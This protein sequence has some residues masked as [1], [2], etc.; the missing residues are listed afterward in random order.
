MASATSSVQLKSTEQWPTTN[1]IKMPQ[2]STA[3]YTCIYMGN[4]RTNSHKNN[5]L[6]YLVLKQDL[7]KSHVYCIVLCNYI[8]IIMYYYHYLCV[9]IL[10]LLNTERKSR[11]YSIQSYLSSYTNAINTAGYCIYETS[12][13]FQQL[14]I[15]HCYITCYTVSICIEFK[16]NTLPEL[17]P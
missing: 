14:A 3:M 16:I 1:S 4:P 15:S 6:G 12:L 8:C 10:L 13:C 17:S 11:K 5:E 7:F 2:L 9:Y